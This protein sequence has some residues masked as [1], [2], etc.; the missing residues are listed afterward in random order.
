[1]RLPDPKS[2]EGQLVAEFARFLD[3]QFEI[4][5]NSNISS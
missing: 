4:V 1:M 3:E 5:S 2:E